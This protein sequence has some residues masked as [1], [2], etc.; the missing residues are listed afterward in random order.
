MKVTLSPMIERV[1]CIPFI[2]LLGYF[3]TVIS[4][5]MKWRMIVHSNIG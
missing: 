3:G 1:I 5:G 2:A 4:K